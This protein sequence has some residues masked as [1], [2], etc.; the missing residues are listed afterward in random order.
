MW[1][2]AFVKLSIVSSA[3]GALVV[4]ASASAFSF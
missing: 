4:I 2:N 3:F 1:F